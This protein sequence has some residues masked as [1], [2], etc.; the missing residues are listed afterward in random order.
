ME[1]LWWEKKKTTGWSHPRQAVLVFMLLA[2]S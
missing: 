2:Y 1:K